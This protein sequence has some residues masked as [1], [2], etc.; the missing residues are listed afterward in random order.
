MRERNDYLLV[1]RRDK[2][3]K[4]VGVH[5]PVLS[6]RAC[7]DW[8]VSC[9]PRGSTLVSVR[10]SCGC[11]AE[12]FFVQT[13]VLLCVDECGGFETGTTCAILWMMEFV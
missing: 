8:F 9:T 2:T 3:E 1:P 11:G 4:C 6:P 12:I 10:Q 13:F 5:P 7:R